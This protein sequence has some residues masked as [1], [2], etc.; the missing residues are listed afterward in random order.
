MSDRIQDTVGI[1]G[2]YDGQWTAA[3]VSAT[4]ALEVEI[5]GGIG[6]GLAT[7][8]KQD[9]M[10]SILST[11]ATSALQ[12]TSIGILN[13]VDT[14]STQ[15][16]LVLDEIESTSVLTKDI[17]DTQYQM[18]DSKINKGVDAT[19]TEA[20]QVLTYGLNTNSNNC[21]AIEVDNVG[22]LKTTLQSVSGSLVMK[23]N[24]ATLNAKVSKGEDASIVS[25]A[26]GLQQI[27]CYGMDNQGDLEPINIDNSGHL[28][29]TI[30]DVDETAIGL[31]MAGETAGG[32]Q[33]NL[34]AG[35]SGNLRTHESL[36]RIN[37]S[38][39]ITIADGATVSGSGI[40]MSDYQYIAFLGDTNNI[41]NKTIFIE[42]S[43]DN[44][45]WY[46]GN[47]DTSKVVIV[48]GTGNFFG[49]ERIITKYVRISRLNSSGAS[50]SLT[51][52]YT[53]A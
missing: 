47:E 50:E 51:I 6:A 49:Q 53:R 15:S 37:T 4:G 24:D 48:S 1:F 21:K 23:T 10:I 27:L 28:K 40:D 11:S 13:S 45:T 43:V 35:N 7:E 16:K 31:K 12:N 17:L 32:S 8:A 41:F 2:N 14:T 19:L 44:I 3:S 5:S 18:L 22:N 38:E 39:T 46:R 25:G 29:I 36:E 20:Q 52:N 34:K 26:G 42:Y 30:N 9:N 33:V